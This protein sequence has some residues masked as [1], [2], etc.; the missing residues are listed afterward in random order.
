[1]E[2]IF[3]REKLIRDLK[4]DRLYF[5]EPNL[6]PWLTIQKECELPLRV[7]HMESEENK[8]RAIDLIEMWA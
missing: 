5:Q 4:E 1:M 3:Q 7:M 2:L 6:L 8:Q